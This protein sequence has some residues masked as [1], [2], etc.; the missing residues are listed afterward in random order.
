MRTFVEELL[1]LITE[2]ESTGR[3]YIPDRTQRHAL[4][5]AVLLELALNRRIDTD[6]EALSVTDP[7]PL[8]D[9]LL[10][11]TLSEIAQDTETR[12]AEFWGAASR[13]PAGRGTARDGQD[14]AVGGR[15]P[16]GRR[17]GGPLPFPQDSPPVALSVSPRADRRF[18]EDAPHPLAGCSVQ[19]RHSIPDGLRHDQC[20]SRLRPVPAN[21]W[22]G[23]NSRS[24]MSA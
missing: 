14:A 2:G 24:S 7:T 15:Y 18:R 5:G 10:D 1:I 23:M 21:Y 6:V 19:R 9:E 17:R 12:T 22:T 8:G 3:A 4:A 20:G 13:R 11:P 16:G